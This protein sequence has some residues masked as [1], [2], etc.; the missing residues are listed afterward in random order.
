MQ[1]EYNKLVRDHIPTI[2]AQ[3]G[4]TYDITTDAP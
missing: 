4:Y 2:L 1:T 3:A